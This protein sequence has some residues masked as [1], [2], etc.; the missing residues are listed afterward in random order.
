MSSCQALFTRRRKTTPEDCAVDKCSNTGETPAALPSF[1]SRWHCSPFWRLKAFRASFLLNY[2]EWA[3]GKDQ[4]RNS[5]RLAEQQGLL[6][7]F[8]FLNF[9]PWVTS[10]F[11]LSLL[12]PSMEQCGGGGRHT[13]LIQHFPLPGCCAQFKKTVRFEN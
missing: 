11:H 4:D 7:F 1:A 6:D 3:S 13:G 8:C 9:S 10:I 5:F 2:S 12:N